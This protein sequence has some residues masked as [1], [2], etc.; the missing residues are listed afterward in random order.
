MGEVLGVAGEVE[1][2]SLNVALVDGCGDEDVDLAFFEVF[3]GA[4]EALAGELAGATVRR[5]SRCSCRGL[6]SPHLE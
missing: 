4:V 1:V 5:L 2:G 6:S 3:A